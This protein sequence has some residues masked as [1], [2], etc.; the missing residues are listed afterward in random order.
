MACAT[1]AAVS[2]RSIQEDD[3]DRVSVG[4]QATC[5]SC[6]EPITFRGTYWDHDGENKPRH[7]AA[8]QATRESILQASKEVCH[9]CDELIGELLVWHHMFAV[10]GTVPHACVGAIIDDARSAIA[11][12]RSLIMMG[13][14]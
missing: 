4:T 5:Q 14:L 13:E 2:E 3:M 11:K 10:P 1:G 6:G 9:A 12:A 7:I 8:P